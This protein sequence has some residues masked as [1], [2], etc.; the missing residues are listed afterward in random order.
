MLNA[1]QR[2]V[3]TSME[4]RLELVV[5]ELDEDTAAAE[6]DLEVLSA[7]LTSLENTLFANP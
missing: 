1:D 6:M 2:D 4:Q 5:G 7:K 3:V